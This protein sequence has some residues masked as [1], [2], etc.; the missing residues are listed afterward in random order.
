MQ[1]GLYQALRERAWMVGHE[2]V[3]LS[4]AAC[5]GAAY[6]LQPEELP[7]ISYPY[8]W[9]FSALQDAALLTL[10]IQRLALKHGMS[11]K[12]AS[13]FNV[14]FQGAR[15]IFIDTLSF[16]QYEE[17]KPWGAYHQF[18]RHFL[19]PLTLMARRDVRQ[20][21]LLVTNIDGIPLDLASC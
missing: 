11:L 18:C 19:A 7:F 12:D 15:P 16:E 20:V 10:D 1:G 8:E 14:Q 4:R 17:G 6:V 21:R 9:A 13:A 5:D 3:D 2:E